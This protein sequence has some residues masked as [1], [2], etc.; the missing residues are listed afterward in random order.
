MISNR[1]PTSPLP[2]LRKYEG[3]PKIVSTPRGRGSRSTPDNTSR[4]A[5]QRVEFVFEG[6]QQHGPSERFPH[7]FH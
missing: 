3:A 4:L 7:I 2:K 5:G 6:R 1:Q